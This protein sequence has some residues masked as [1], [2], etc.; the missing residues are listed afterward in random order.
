MRI[1]YKYLL[2]VGMLYLASCTPAK[3]LELPTSLEI[4]KSLISNSVDSFDTVT[5]QPWKTFFQDEKLIALIDTAL[6]QNW[7]VLSAYQRIEYARAQ[8]K[9]AKGA[10]LPSV[11]I[12]VAASGDRYGKYTM[13]GVGNFDTNLS[14][15]I[16]DDQKI[17][18][19][20]S[21]D[22]FIGARS[23]WEVDLF[24]KLKN[25][26]LAAQLEMKAAEKSVQLFQ[27]A[28]VA[29]ISSL[30]YDLIS[31]DKE[32]AVIQKNIEL[33]STAK[34]IVEVQKMGGRA[35]ELA[36][37]QF[38]AQL[39]NTKALEKD[40]LIEIN[41]VENQLNSLIGRFPQKVERATDLSEVNI[42]N[43]FERG[44]SS[45]MLL[46]R[47]DI[48]EAEL[49][50]AAQQANVRAARAALLP[51]LTITPQV[52]F[53]SFNASKLFDPASL[54]FGVLG[55]LSQP[56]LNRSAILANIDQNNA[57]AL[58]AFYQYQKTIVNSFAEVNTQI[59]KIINL[60]EKVQLKEDEYTFIH[61]AI[62]TSKDLYLAGYANYLEVITAQKSAL[63]VELDLINTKKHLLLSSILLYRSL[64]GGWN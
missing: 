58:D 49:L 12:D 28:L 2:G 26:K 48:Q 4:P 50:L 44:L 46:N 34:E 32:L 40:V 56:F 45:N 51:G 18:T 57:A 24:G 3:K 30:Y 23:F 11:S 59:T 38:T 33:Q 1:Q 61:N 36:V 19:D 7:D 63:E 10:M 31:L 41:A 8:Y 35:T 47:P 60:K 14:S 39:L 25:Q 54:A 62:S 13:T 52:G 5:I 15:N 16:T 6:A 64:G 22:F 43:N 53:T 17:N 42:V 37:Q 9:R 21:P 27:T 29:E 20:F 55:G